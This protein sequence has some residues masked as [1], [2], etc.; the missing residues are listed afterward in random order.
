MRGIGMQALKNRD[1][2]K[3]KLLTVCLLLIACVCLFFLLRYVIILK[4]A[5]KNTRY[6]QEN[7]IST[8]DSPAPYYNSSSYENETADGFTIPELD[9]DFEALREEVNPDIYSWILIP[10]TPINY[11]I[12]Q[13]PDDN[14][15]YIKYNLDGSKG[16]PGCIFTE[17]YNSRD[18]NDVNTIVYGHNMR[19]GS[20][21]SKLNS[22]ADEDFFE[23]HPYIYIYSPDAV[24]VYQ[25]FA[26]YEFSDLHLMAA[27][28]W[29]DPE[30][31][32]R[33]FSVISGYPG[34][35]DEAVELNDDDRYL[36]LSTCRNFKQDKRFLIHAL[37]ILDVM[38]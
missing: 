14:T 5:E 12:V 37:L 20:M 30:I 7:Y 13:H 38:K 1:N 26:A 17:N 2:K 24:R 32:S 21:F 28:D 22:F 35:Y 27:C 25:A 34:I 9:I 6:I 29:N 4:N 15:H 10:D 8:P 11:P 23:E 18:W 19:N 36:T 33:F 31:V 3:L 16:Y